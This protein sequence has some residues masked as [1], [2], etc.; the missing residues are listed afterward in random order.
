MPIR[1]IFIRL[2]FTMP[3]VL[4]SLSSDE[5]VC[6]LS[7]LDL[8]LLTSYPLYKKGRTQNKRRTD[9]STDDITVICSSALERHC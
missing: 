8:V 3:I 1:R 5:I 4:I 2:Q 9:M 7:L 6:A